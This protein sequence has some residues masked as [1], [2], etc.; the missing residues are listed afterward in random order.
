MDM[1]GLIAKLCAEHKIPLL[2]YSTD[3]VFGD[4]GSNFLTPEYKKKPYCIYGQSKL[5]GEK[6]INKFVRLKNLRVIILRISW[7][8]SENSNNFVNTILNL[9][10]KKDRIKIINDQIGGPTSS[11]SIALATFKIINSFLEIKPDYKNHFPWGEYH[12]QGTPVVSWFQ[13]ACFIVDEAYKLGL[14][15]KTTN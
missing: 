4:N 2:Q 1:V 3:Y 10:R 7:V 14:I 6:L 12:F 15:G 5:L 9:S 13:F 8:F 11:D